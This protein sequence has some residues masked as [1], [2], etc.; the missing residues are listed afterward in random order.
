[1][2]INL[3]KAFV[4]ISYNGPLDTMEAAVK[5]GNAEALRKSMMHIFVASTFLSLVCYCALFSHA[6]DRVSSEQKRLKKREKERVS[7]TR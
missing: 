6:T 7:S 3:L 5:E 2:F 4:Y 1:M